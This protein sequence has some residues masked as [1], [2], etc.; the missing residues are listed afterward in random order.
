MSARTG[1]LDRIHGPEDLRGLSAAELRT[2]AAE[3]R[4]FLVDRILRRKESLGPLALPAGETQ[5][6]RYRFRLDD[7]GKLW[8]RARGR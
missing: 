7:L 2:L 3:I 6:L 8:H 4:D 1:L 5:A